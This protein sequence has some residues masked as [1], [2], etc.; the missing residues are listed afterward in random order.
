MLRSFASRAFCLNARCVGS[1]LSLVRSLTTLRMVR[2][3]F[4]SACRKAKLP[5]WSM[6]HY[7][8]YEGSGQPGSKS[9]GPRPFERARRVLSNGTRE[10]FWFTSGKVTAKWKSDF[11]VLLSHKLGECL[12][13]VS[14]PSRSRT[15]HRRNCEGKLFFGYN[16]WQE[17]S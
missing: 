3:N 11:W 14:E 17:T 16:F 6:R 15:D 5:H 13:W 2:T 7:S 9:T 10:K 12:T 8:Q 1:K 4:F